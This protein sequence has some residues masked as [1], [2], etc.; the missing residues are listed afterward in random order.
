M[1]SPNKFIRKYFNN[2]IIRKNISECKEQK[3]AEDTKSY[4]KKT[5]EQKWF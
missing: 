1:K 3:N 4:R 2:S 5:T